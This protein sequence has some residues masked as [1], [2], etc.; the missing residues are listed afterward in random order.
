MSGTDLAYGRIC[1]RAFYI[2]SGTDPAYSFIGIDER[3]TMSGTD[4][5]DAC[6]TR[7][8]V[9]ATRYPALSYRMVLSGAL[10]YCRKAKDGWLHNLVSSYAMSGTDSAFSAIRLRV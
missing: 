9:L 10:Y 3:Y 5:R 1:L 4:Q 8:P 7:S 6:A 2:M